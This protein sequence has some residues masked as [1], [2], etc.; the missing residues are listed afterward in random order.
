M[1]IY[2]A[3]KGIGNTFM[4]SFRPAILDIKISTHMRTM[5]EKCFFHKC[6]KSAYFLS[7][8]SD[9]DNECFFLLGLGT[10]FLLAPLLVSKQ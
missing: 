5:A 2:L 4:H 6:A 3:D 1:A 9:M 7:A 10:R 8:S